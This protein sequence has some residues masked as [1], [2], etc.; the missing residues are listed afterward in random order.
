MS[1]NGVLNDDRYDKRVRY[2]SRK[3]RAHTRKRVK[4]R[5]VKSREITDV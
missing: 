3:A 2:E 4:G 1:V 5:Y